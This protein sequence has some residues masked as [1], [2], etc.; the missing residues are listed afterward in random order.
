[1][2]AIVRFSFCLLILC[3]F[4]ACKNQESNKEDKSEDTTE[5]KE[6]TVFEGEE[7]PDDNRKVNVTQ[8]GPAEDIKHAVNNKGIGPVTEVVLLNEI[9]EEMVKE[10]KEL[11]NNNCHSC[12]RIH[13]ST[14]GPALGNVLERRSPEF[15]M[16]MIL[17]TKE[18]IEEEPIIMALKGEYESEMVQLDLTQE[19]AR[20]IVEYLRT[21]Q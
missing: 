15:V 2:K 5:R 20:K 6:D 3:S 4:G 18:M 19:E 1:M 7:I 10:G 21:Y 12:H 17:N 13:E 11:Y 14:M 16:N 9:D 8:S